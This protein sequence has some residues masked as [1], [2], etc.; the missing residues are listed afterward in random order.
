MTGV[1][2]K[3]GVGVKVSVGVRVGSSG[4]NV[5]AAVG[6]SKPVMGMIAW[7]VCVNAATMVW[8]IAVFM[9]LE[10]GLEIPGTVQAWERIN[11]I[12]TDKRIGVVF[13]KFPPFR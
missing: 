3:T 12:E 11:K 5:C 4:V 2:V 1:E 8:A 7:E 6:D 9:E 10:S 13:S